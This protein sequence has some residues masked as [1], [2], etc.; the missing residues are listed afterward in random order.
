M[1]HQLVECVPNFSEGRDPKK[2]EQILDA[3][4]EVA[5]IELLDVD[6]GRDTNRTVVTF[7]GAPAAVEEAAFRAI[8]RAATVIDMS[9]HQGAH[10]RHGATDVCPFIPISGVS[11]ADCVEIAR[12]LGR[13][14]GDDLQIP[15]YLYEHA[16]QRPERRSLAA[17]RKGEYE[18]LPEKLA[19]P[20]W[21]PDFGPARFHA[22]AGVVTIGAREFLIAYNINLNSRDVEHARDLA[23]EIREKGRA[24]RVDQR[25]PFYSSGKLVK[26]QPAK[27]RFPCAYCPEVAGTWDA[28]AEHSRSR[29]A[30]E[31]EEELRFLEVDPAHLEDANVMRRGLFRECRAVGWMIPEYGR[32][33]ISINLTN[34][35][36]TPTH[37]VLERCRQLA[38]DRQL[39]VTG[40]EIV[41]L[42]P[43]EA[44][45]ESGE[46]YLARQGSSRGLPVHD[47]I[48]TAV[49]SLG[50][51]DLG[52]FDA[53]KSVLGLPKRDGTLISKRVH[54]LVD[55]V[56]RPSPVP[57]GGSLAA[58]AGSFGAALGCM[59][60]NI[61]H[62]KPKLRAVHE[63]MEQTAMQCQ[64]V[65]DELLR[66]VDDDTNAF[67]DVI[68]A[69][70]LPKA[71]AAEAAARD[72]AIQAG[73]QRA[74]LVPLRTAELCLEGLKAC[75]V[76]A[77]DGYAPSVTDAGVGGLLAHAGL[78]GA[79]Y[80]V[81]INLGSI[82]DA[83][84]VTQIRAQLGSLTDAAQRIADELDELIRG[85]LAG[86]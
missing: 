50:L 67:T 79:V 27:G 30:F 39:V 61:S 43:Y 12:R 47:V 9:R 41:G 36:V 17:V 49:Q 73:Y 58:L 20:E 78:R 86:Q 68:A 65:K 4:R 77:R 24:V 23:S 6:P 38:T 74:T 26:Y 1:A 55:E 70:R 34:Y 45:R 16:A 18:A 76:A 56:S 11:M 32:A 22:R 72:A 63:L 28:L 82:T 31:L 5:G 15:V 69:M 10:P 53:D 44:M 57:G 33:Q 7:V 51:R 25:T 35:K 85:Q 8:A 64:G 3:I 83:A 66:A 60:G 54:E 40:S 71:T 42:V 48:E 13:R 46:Y 29:H 52:A 84:W 62:S 59:V 80:N 14:V 19:R 81:A 21:A 75:L 37:A 2:I